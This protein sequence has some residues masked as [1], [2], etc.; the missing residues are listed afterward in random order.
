VLLRR[1]LWEGG[2]HNEIN[3][4]LVSWEKISKPLMEG[5]LHLWDVSSQNLDLGAKILW[6][7]VSGKISYSK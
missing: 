5:G 7:I 2:R 6:Q 4:H 1:F 3:L